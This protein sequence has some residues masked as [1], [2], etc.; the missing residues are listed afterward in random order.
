[1][2]CEVVVVLRLF[3]THRLTKPLSININCNTEATKHED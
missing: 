2:E 1:M 3:C